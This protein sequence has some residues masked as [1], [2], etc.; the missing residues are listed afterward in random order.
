MLTTT[1]MGVRNLINQLN[2]YLLL[3][4]SREALTTV[5]VSYSYTVQSRSLQ[6]LQASRVLHVTDPPFSIEDD[7]EPQQQH[8]PGVRELDHIT[9]RMG[10]LEVTQDRSSLEPTSLNSS[11]EERMDHFH[12]DPITGHIAT[13]TLDPRRSARLRPHADDM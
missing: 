7:S 3:M 1:Y 13:L 10:K 4:I 5:F 2:L 8:F 6:N 9:V 11:Q 12:I